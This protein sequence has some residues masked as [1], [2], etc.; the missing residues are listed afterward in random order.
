M[1]KSNTTIIIC[2]A[3]MGTR[4]G[5]GTTKC[6]I[7][8]CGK[9]LIIRLLDQLRDYDDIRIVVGYQAQRVIEVVKEY[10][11]NVMFAFNYD[12]ETTGPA[13]SM[14][15][16]LLCAKE[17]II[18]LDGDLVINTKDFQKF[19]EYPN[20]CVTYCEKISD[21]PVSIEIKENKAISFKNRSNKYEWPGIVKINKNHI[22]SGDGYIYDILEKNLPI[23]AI[24]VDARGIDTQ[25]DYERVINWVNN[26]YKN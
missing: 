26:N 2:C 20:E 21:E 11:K 4:L 5:I 6:L 13:A 8:I 17:N 24:H 22:N 9:P 25:D 3:G 10:N 18:I 7:D 14:S 23:D 19:L 1:E 15:K 12:Y 16:A